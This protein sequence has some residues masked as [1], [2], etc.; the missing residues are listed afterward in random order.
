MRKF[1]YNRNIKYNKLY[2]SLSCILVTVIGFLCFQVYTYYQ[3]RSEYTKLVM[4]RDEYELLT[5]EIAVYKKFKIQYEVISGE[6]SDLMVKKTNM[7]EQVYNL[8][9]EIINLKSKISDISDK[10]KKLS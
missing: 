1:G 4:L 5:D 8:N 6:S 10:I 3:L 7:E 9:K 2:I